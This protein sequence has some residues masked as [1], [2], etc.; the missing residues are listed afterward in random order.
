MNSAMGGF[1]R[2]PSQLLWETKVAVACDSLTVRDLDLKGAGG[3]FIE[4][5][6]DSS[7]G[8]SVMVSVNDILSNTQYQNQYIYGSNT[9]L[10]GLRQTERM[11]LVFSSV[12]KEGYGFGE[13][14]MTPSGIVV[15]SSQMVRGL[16]V[17]GGTIDGG[18][19]MSQ[20]LFTVNNVTS[21]TFQA[22]GANGIGVG[23]EFRIFAKR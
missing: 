22:D 21:I 5:A 14:G 9:S 20:S 15:M 7:V 16:A 2:R 17:A 8:C 3:F 19:F 13:M 23:C 6:K 4:V 1:P 10:A 12:G 11:F 18:L